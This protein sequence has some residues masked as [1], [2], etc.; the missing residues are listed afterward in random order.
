[1]VAIADAGGARQ[2]QL[3]SL[4]RPDRQ[5]SATEAEQAIAYEIAAE[6]AAAI[7][8]GAADAVLGRVALG[9]EEG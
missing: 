4:R 1:L 3:V 7:G 5:R 2:A 9:K 8:Q 6:G